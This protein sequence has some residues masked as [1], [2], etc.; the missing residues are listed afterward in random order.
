MRESP[1][2]KLLEYGQSPWLDFIQRSLVEGGELERMIDEWGLRGV[3]SNPVIFEK[4]I[5]RTEEYDT[6]IAECARAGHDAGAIY[7][8]LAM[9]DVGRAADVLAPVYEATQGRDGFVSLEVSPHLADDADGT[10]SEARR[11][12]QALARPNVMLKVPGTAAGLEA[13]R[14]LIAEGINVNVTLLFSVERYRQV[15]DAHLE[16][17]ERAAGAGRPVDRTASVASFFL[18]RIDSLVDKALD[19]IAHDR[20]ETAGRAGA[21]RGEAAIASARLAYAV[22]EEFVATARFRAL[23]GR[24]ARPQ[25]LLWASTGT[26]DPAYG[27][28][29]Y[30]EA[31]IGPDT[32]STMPLE[33]LTAYDD[34]GSPAPR[35][36]GHVDEA[37]KVIQDLAELGIDQSE[38]AERLVEEGIDKFA[39]PFDALLE[40]I[41]I[42]RRSALKDDG[43]S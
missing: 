6:A 17:L 14:T 4:A 26:K 11:L 43:K 28:L 38:V 35:L 7:E 34:H 36:V 21:L 9:H 31:L 41:E 29:K 32:V 40:V 1:L 24:G 25:R 37:R 27:D 16:G 8:S 12:W 5:V 33:T 3:T 22:Y 30:V 39:E 10:I 15:L 20:R 18:S 23:A 19:R 2:K 13:V 42:A